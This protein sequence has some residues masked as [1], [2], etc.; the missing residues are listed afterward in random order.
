MVVFKRGL[1]VQDDDPF[2]LGGATLPFAD[3]YRYLGLIFSSSLAWRIHGKS[4]IDRVRASAYAITGM[5]QR[6]GSPA[7][8]S[9]A[10]L[11]QA[12]CAA[13]IG[14]C[15]P[16]F[17]PDS[18]LCASLDN[19]MALP[20]RRALRLP[21]RTPAALLLAEVGL[22]STE[23]LCAQAALRFARRAVTLP[24]Q[25]PTAVL[26]RD[27][28]RGPEQ[29]A[30]RRWEEAVGGQALQL[31]P[32][33]TKERLLMRQLAS[34]WTD[35]KDTCVPLLTHKFEPGLSVYLLLDDKHTASRRA[36]LRFDRSGLRASLAKRRLVPSPDCPDCKGAVD[37]ADHV[38]LTC[39]AFAGPRANCAAALAQAGCVLSTELALGRVEH[40]PK[41]KQA[42]AL[43]ATSEL[44]TAIERIG[45]RRIA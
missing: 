17:Q 34:G 5:V 14:H 4:L 12:I 38:L 11:V 25:H 37:D 8:R 28:A 2:S 26:W 13:Q 36:R 45:A 31:G 7:A 10:K 43:L 15:M 42:A 24:E 19:L 23:H 21:R 3:S 27:E 1:A 16:V 41:R 35:G 32:K 18:A 6:G 44:L 39:P 20:I 30:V 40:L 9:V 22:M 29:S 33:L